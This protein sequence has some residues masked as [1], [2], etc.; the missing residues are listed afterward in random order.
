VPELPE[1]ETIRLQLKGRVVGRR[2]VA[3]WGFPSANFRDAVRAVGSRIVDLR[4]RGKYLLAALGSSQQADRGDEAPTQELVLHLGMTGRLGVVPSCDLD[5]DAAHLRAWW[6]LDDATAVT[7]HDVRR[8]GRVA[9]L[10]AGDHHSLATLHHLGPEPFDDAFTGRS[11][12]SH[13]RGRRA[14]KTVLLAQRAVAG[15]GNIYA[16]EAL[17]SAGVDP[18]TRR[19]GPERAERL[20]DAVREVL[21]DGLAH[22]GTTL[23]DYRDAVGGTGSHQDSLRCYGRGGLPCLACGTALRSTVLDGRRTTWCPGCQ[24]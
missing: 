23:R 10:P 19:L 20:R 8:F 22:G 4:R 11:L 14:V 17:W 3:A 1:V 24:R 6:E 16:D 21:A 9:V 15:V 7:F 2:I 5:R 13:L 18:R 12:R